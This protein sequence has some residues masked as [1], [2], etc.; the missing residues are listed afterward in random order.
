MG[1][2]NIYCWNG[3]VY[4]SASG[5]ILTN[6]G[7]MSIVEDYVNPST[8]PYKINAEERWDGSG[9]NFLRFYGTFL[10]AGAMYIK[11]YG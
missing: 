8:G 5:G 2:Q 7:V 6:G 3:R 1:G 11:I 10:S 9:S 4:L